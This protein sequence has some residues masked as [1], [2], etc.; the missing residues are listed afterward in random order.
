[1]S[2]NEVLGYLADRIADRHASHPLRV[3]ID[4]VSAAGKTTLADELAPFVEAR[5][6]RVVRVMAD[7]FGRPA[8]D[9]YV[10]GHESAEGYYRDAFDYDSLKALLLEPLGPGGSRRIKT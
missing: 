7:D 6:R 3:A 5:G 4:G 1:M 8:P 10:R 9:R 2:R